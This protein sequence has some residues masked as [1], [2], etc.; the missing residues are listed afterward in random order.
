MYVLLIRLLHL[1]FLSLS[2]DDSAKSHPLATLNPLDSQ[3][4][5]EFQCFSFARLHLQAVPF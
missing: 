3:K 4:K 1:V 5:Q 2:L